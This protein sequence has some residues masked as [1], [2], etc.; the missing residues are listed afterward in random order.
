M[1]LPSRKSVPLKYKRF[2]IQ[3]QASLSLDHLTS[4]VDP[5]L[6][7][8][9]YGQVVPFTGK[10]F[11]E[12]SRQDDAEFIASWF[13]A[14]SC[15]REILATTRGKDVEDTLRKQLL[16]T[17]WERIPVFAIPNAALGPV[18]PIIAY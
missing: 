10:P 14:I 5:A 13:E 9:P 2:D 4:F 11:A 6:D 18:I 12:H 7:F 1:T 3:A 15:T 16:E 8:L 17:G